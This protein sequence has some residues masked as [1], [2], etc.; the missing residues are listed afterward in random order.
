M[1]Q[2]LVELGDC[3]DCVDWDRLEEDSLK[4][5]QENVVGI[6]QGKKLVG[7]DIKE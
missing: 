3:G 7:S 2:I 4:K 6:C 1:N 5:D